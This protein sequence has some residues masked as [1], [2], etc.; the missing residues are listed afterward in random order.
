MSISGSRR[1]G[2]RMRCGSSGGCPGRVSSTGIVTGTGGVGGRRWYLLGV[3]F[4][5]LVVVVS[6]FLFSA[7]SAYS[8]VLSAVGRW[9]FCFCFCFGW[10]MIMIG[11][12]IQW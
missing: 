5:A 12:R 2:I 3:F 8:R 6:A 11:V 7:A 10:V 9:G 1:K 4:L